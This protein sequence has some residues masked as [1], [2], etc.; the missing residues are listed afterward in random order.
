MAKRTWYVI[1]A[2]LFAP[3]LSLAE[4]DNR[5]KEEIAEM[6]SVI[7]FMD[8][9]CPIARYHARTLRIL[10]EEYS[11]KG[12]RFTA[13]FPAASATPQ[14]IEAFTKK[15][16]FPLKSLPDA[17]Q[18]KAQT[19]EATTVPEV[20]VFDRNEKLIYRGRIDDR[21]AAVGKRRPNTRKHDLA[22]IL[23]S[24]SGGEKPKPRQTEAI[25]CAITFR[26]PKEKKS[27]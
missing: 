10:H 15:F 9:G 7:V 6:A 3:S 19:L 20:F 8:T 18:K 5:E 4:D 26:Q 27:P 13:L 16:Q 24:L 23:R 22:D 12:I 21:F 1:C 14:S 11:Q 17:G 2:L 25:G